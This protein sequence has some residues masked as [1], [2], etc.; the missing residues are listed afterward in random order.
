MTPP[1]AKRI[2][3]VFA[4]A[5]CTGWLHARR[6]GTPTGDAGDIAVGD[7]SPDSKARHR[8]TSSGSL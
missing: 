2:R 5:G 1:A 3:D 4:D 7:N 8:A 6:V